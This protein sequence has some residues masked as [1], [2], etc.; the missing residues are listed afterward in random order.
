[1]REARDSAKGSP[2][3]LRRFARGQETLQRTR[4]E[5]LNGWHAI[6]SQLRDSGKQELADRV[7]HFV[8]QMP[9]P[10]TDQVQLARQVGVHGRHPSVD[11]IER[12][13]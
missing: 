1:M 4:L 7:D 3:S 13:R 5:V 12:M 9:P 2:E 11:P 6:A 10:T 8:Q